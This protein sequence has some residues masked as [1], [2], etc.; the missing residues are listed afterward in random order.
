MQSKG[1]QQQNYLSETDGK[2]WWQLPQAPK[3][4]G[5]KCKLPS[6]TVPNQDVRVN[7]VIGQYLNG[8]IASG[9]DPADAQWN[10]DLENPVG[11]DFRRLDLSELQE[12]RDRE[13]K[14]IDDINEE[15][16]KQYA[17]A[18]EKEKQKIF[19]DE[20]EKRKKADE[21]AAEH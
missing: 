4:E 6:L 10:D 17:E 21:E 2:M 16:A 15:I 12:L 8:M 20:I 19:D 1:S 9:N 14:K 5:L 13:R 3:L 11:I 18:D 7:D